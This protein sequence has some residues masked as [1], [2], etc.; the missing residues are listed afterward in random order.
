MEV[1]FK[2]RNLTLKTVKQNIFQ[3]FENRL[4]S[5]KIKTIRHLT[6]EYIILLTY[7]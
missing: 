7:F 6:D 4:F 3:P 1:Y 5:K 2:R